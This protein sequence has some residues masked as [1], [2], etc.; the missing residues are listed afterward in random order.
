MSSY[1]FP[2]ISHAHSTYDLR[3]DSRIYLWR[4]LFLGDF[5]V[6]ALGHVFLDKSACATVLL[7]RVFAENGGMMGA[8]LVETI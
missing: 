3:Y 2:C 8:G 7:F 1:V 6:L 4:Q 5:H